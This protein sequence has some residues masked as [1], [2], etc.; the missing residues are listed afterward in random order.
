[1][2]PITRYLLVE[3]LLGLAQDDPALR[4][5]LPIAVDPA[6]PSVLAD[7]L[8]ATIA[9]LH[10]RLDAISTADVARLVGATLMQRT[11]PEP[12]APLAQLVAAD[13]L[14]PGAPLRL[15]P[16][17]RVRIDAAGGQLQLVLLDR[18]ISLPAEAADAVKL[19]LAGGAFNPGQLPGLDADEQL[20]VCRRLL[21]EG[22]LVP[23]S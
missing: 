20:T 14:G 21:R 17:L 10:D 7:E 4:R 2:H 6:D 19:A 13:Q 18:T 11:R 9:A 16:G 5:S 3:H 23:V 12:I 15:R 1:V 8:S 22:V